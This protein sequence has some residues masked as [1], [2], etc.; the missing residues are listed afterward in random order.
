MTS[1]PS[2][3]SFPDFSA[4]TE[5]GPSKSD[6]HT[7]ITSFG[8]FPELI[9]PKRSSRR[10]RSP[11]DFREERKSRRIDD[12]AYK[13]GSSKRDKYDDGREK[14]RKDRDKRVKDESERYKE[15]RRDRSKSRDRYKYRDRDRSTDR[16]RGNERDRSAERRYKED[17]RRREREQALNLIRGEE[18]TKLDRSKRKEEKWEKKEDGMAWYESVGKVKNVQED[19]IPPSNSFF[20]DT[21]GDRDAVKYGSTSS[22]SAPRYY[23]EGKNRVLGLN[24]GLRIVYSRDRTEK[25]V[26]IAPMGRP[27]VPRY[28]SRQARSAAS[29]HLQRIL[30]QSTNDQGPFN[31]FANYLHFEIKRNDQ[32]IDLP[33]YR[34]I[35]Q[36]QD[37]DDGLVA[38]QAAI[39]SYSTL[40]E[41]VRKETIA[42]EGF[43]REHPDNIERWIDYSRLHLKLSPESSNQNQSERSNK[44]RAEA[45]VTLSILSRALDASEKN[46]NSSKLHLAYLKAAEEFWAIE[47]VTNRWKNVLRELGERGN[48][49]IEMMDLWLGYIAWREGHGFAGQGGG[50]DE[51]V[52]VYEE[53]ITRLKGNGVAVD[54]QAREENMVY[55]FLR[56]AL[57]LKQAGYTER[58]LASFQALIEITFFKPDHLRQPSGITLTHDSFDK[59][60]GEFEKFWDTGA[61]RIGETGSKGWQNTTSNL[62][63]IPKV[64]QSLHHSSEDPFERWLEAET[65][66]ETIYTLPGRATDLDTEVEDDPYHVILFSDIRPFLFNIISPIVRLQLIYAFLTFLGLPFTPPDSTSSSPATNDPHLSWTLAHNPKKRH[67]FWPSRQGQ[68][69]LP[70]QTVGGEPMDPERSRGLESPFESPVKCWSQD[71]STL[72]GKKD[73]WFT[74]LGS[75]DI[76]GLDIDLIRNAFSLLRPLVPDPAFTLANF[77]FEAA[78]SPKGAVKLAKSILVSDRDNLLLWE[79]YARLE[80]QRGNFAAARTVYITALQAAVAHRKDGLVTEDELDLWAGWSEMEFEMAEDVRALEVVSLAVGSG[81]DRLSDYSVP[82][83]MPTPPA[84]IALLKARQHYSSISH[85]LSPSQL[86]LKSLYSYLIDG[87]EPT[88]TFLLNHLAS[89]PPSSPEAEQTLQLLTKILYLHSSRHASPASLSRSTLEIALSSFPNNTSFLS[90][91]LYGELGGRVYGRIQRLISDLTSNRENNGGLTIYLWAIWAQGVSSHRTFWDANGTGSERVRLTLDKAVNSTTGKCSAALWILYIEFEVLM[92]RYN[93]AKQLCYRAVTSLGGCKALYLLP[94]SKSLRSHYTLREL[95]DWSELILERGIRIRIPF[96]NYFDNSL[97]EGLLE[98]LP[99]DEDL[100]DDELG[101]L[102]QR[103]IA[104]PY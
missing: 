49:E 77:A 29:E 60:L 70:W 12:E 31:P 97:D 101:F 76:A 94:F 82:D 100:K 19:E 87:I 41:E 34:D 22:S 59:A 15:R 2:F 102:T 30:L 20:C 90:L 38:I 52:E 88:R 71:R 65:H 64:T 16:N 35:H 5:A 36:N 43:L 75:V 42:I 6:S 93:N 10:S 91:Y 85:T 54:V 28:N 61:P 73:K 98:D 104:K 44:T 24:E 50:V 63:S 95:K 47:K 72:L 11:P 4:N 79:G 37:E 3:S 9:E 8:S 39:G 69:K 40:E 27:Y 99:K 21:V 80:K 33:S 23:R 14:N 18:D 26:E 45:E 92:G 53:C 46:F 81:Q 78:V 56:A 51:V 1:T 25:G 67:L 58:A 66:A 17:R 103:E 13:K 7:A 83:R 32:A 86:L 57:F 62:V 74:D 48:S 55:L 68:R 96:E 84:P 89:L